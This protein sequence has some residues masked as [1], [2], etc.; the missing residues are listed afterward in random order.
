MSFSGGLISKGTGV[1]IAADGTGD[2]QQALGVSDTDLIT[3][4]KHPNIKM[5]ARYKPCAYEGEETPTQQQY[6]DNYFFVKAV[7]ATSKSAL[8]SMAMGWTYE[9]ADQYCRQLDFVGY[10]V[11]PNT[12]PTAPF[13][14]ANGSTLIVDLISGNANPALFYLFMRTGKLAN[15]RF[16]ASGG[17]DTGSSTAVP[18]NR[19]AYAMTCEDLGFYDGSGFHELL[20]GV[21]GLVIFDSNGTEKGEVWATKN[22]NEI[23]VKDDYSVIENDMFKVRTD[24]LNLA[25]GTYVAVACAKKEDDMHTYYLPVFND[26][27]YP[28][29]F[30]LVVGGID[31]YKQDR[32]GISL[33]DSSGWANDISYNGNS[34]SDIYVK[35]YLYNQTGRSVTL[36]VRDNRFA[37]STK[38]STINPVVDSR[39]S[40]TFE[41]T[42]TSQ[43]WLPTSDVTVANNGYAE[44]IFKITNIWGESA[45][46]SPTLIESG[47]L[48]VEPTLQ[49][50]SG[51]TATDFPLYG[52][53]RTFTVTHVN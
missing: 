40:H 34:Q 27:S 33:S 42:Q 10:Y 31:Y 1:L 14:Q 5:F 53:Q 29:K 41:R 46:S 9:G 38:V 36:N 12:A 19:L 22:G 2:I 15:K 24:G 13:M 43:L 35:M 8:F 39:G 47:K 52:P 32:Q 49:F 18:S 7:A 25:V 26:A 48:L 51:G 23:P 6:A 45:G 17:I 30:S 16:S 50:V 11:L 3:L 20:E 21:L 4:C 37:L 28:A 44:L